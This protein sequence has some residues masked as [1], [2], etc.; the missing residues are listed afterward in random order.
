MTDPPFIAAAAVAELDPRAVMTAV[1]DALSGLA[2]GA[3]EQPAQTLIPFPDGRSDCI[4]HCGLVAKRGVLGVKVSPYLAA[5]PDRDVGVV[6]AYTLLVS[7]DDGVPKLLCDSAGLTTART[8][9][10]TALAVDLLAPATRAGNGAPRSRPPGS[11]CSP[12]R[13]RRTP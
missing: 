7:L 12:M 9:A 2:D 10:T 8:A 3:S 5:G 6:T 13:R 4:V 11:T 1:A